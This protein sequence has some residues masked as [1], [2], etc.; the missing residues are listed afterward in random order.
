MCMWVKSGY[1]QAKEQ[2]WRSEDNLWRSSPS[3]LFE[4][5]S[6]LF[7]FCISQGIWPLSFRGFSLS[8]CLPPPSKSDKNTNAHATSLAFA[9]VL[10]FKLRSSCLYGN[11]FYSPDAVFS[12]VEVKSHTHWY[13]MYVQLC[14]AGSSFKK[15]I[16]TILYCLQNLK[17][18]NSPLLTNAK[19]YI[20]F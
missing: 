8:F 20:M 5:R 9:W 18:K 17:N 1:V 10:Q 13:Y 16:F 3:T 6:L 7:F 4:T 11:C 19:K 14:T 15:Q 12:P 2:T